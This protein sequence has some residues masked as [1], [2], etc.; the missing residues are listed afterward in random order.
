MCSLQQP[1]EGAAVLWVQAQRGSKAPQADECWVRGPDPALSS[2]AS[3]CGK[4]LLWCDQVAGWLKE[5]DRISQT[6]RDTEPPL[7]AISFWSFGTRCPMLGVCPVRSLGVRAEPVP[8]H[9]AL[10][11]GTSFWLLGGKPL[12]LVKRQLT[13]IA[14]D[15]FSPCFVVPYPHCSVWYQ[16]LFQTVIVR[17]G[18]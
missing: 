18:N 8:G 16:S 3:F 15:V 1:A 10:P 9:G 2:S 17:I 6:A 13:T 11:V 12:W 5:A 7:G 4:R 14:T